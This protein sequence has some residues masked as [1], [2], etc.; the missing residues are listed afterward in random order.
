MRAANPFARHEAECAEAASARTRDRLRLHATFLD[1]A[2]LAARDRNWEAHRAFS[3]A[4]DLALGYVSW[5]VDR[6]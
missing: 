4:A 6:E 5:V 3:M 1:Y 2:A